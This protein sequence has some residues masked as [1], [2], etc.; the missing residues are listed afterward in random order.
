MQDANAQLT[1]LENVCK[2]RPTSSNVAAL[3]ASYFTLNDP[4]RALPLALM[5]WNKNRDP[6]IGMNLALIYK[7]LGMHKEAFETVQYAYWLNPSDAYIQLGYGEALLKAGFWDR[8]W[9]IYDNARPTQQGAAL[10]LSVPSDV[11]E[12]DGKATD[13]ELLVINEGGMGDRLSYARWLPE[14][15]KMGVDWKFYPYEPSWAFFERIFPR[16]RLIHYDGEEMNP[17]YWTTTFSLPAKLNARPTNVP[18]PLQFTATTEA[19]AQYKF[20]RADNL[21]IVGICYE[22]AE[23]FQGGRKV[24]SLTEGQAMRLVTM[25]ADRVHWV[26]LQ[27]NAKMPYPVDNVPFYSWQDTAGLITNLDGVVSVDTAIMHLAGGMGKPLAVPL[28]GNSCW[29][30]L[31]KGSECIWYPTATLFRNEGVGMENA[32]TDLTVAIRNGLFHV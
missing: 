30:F 24:R 32:I 9:P 17:K 10:N 20:N 19:A 8:A 27:H 4:K 3:A 21:P 5:A 14:L 1:S 22:A 31:L 6:N 26:S 7:D 12:W 15:T 29:K 2:L 13:G 11:K 25:T 28:S 18:K 16:E 23:A